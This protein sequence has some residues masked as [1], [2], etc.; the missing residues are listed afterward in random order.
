MIWDPG[1]AAPVR[2]EGSSFVTGSSPYVGK[3]LRG[4]IHET[5]LRGQLVFDGVGHPTHHAASSCSTEEIT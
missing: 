3:T 4:R 2:S 1:R 5:W